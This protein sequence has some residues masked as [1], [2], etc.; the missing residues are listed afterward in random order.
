MVCSVD[1]KAIDVYVLIKHCV[2]HS[3]ET[4]LESGIFESAGTII[5]DLSRAWI[6]RRKDSI[7]LT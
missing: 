6:H 3:K 5:V 1:Y 2:R 7:P 4:I